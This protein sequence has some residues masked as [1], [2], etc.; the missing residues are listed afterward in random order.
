MFQNSSRREFI[1][2]MSAALASA[3]GLAAQSPSFFRFPYVQDVRRTRATI[4]WTTLAP[5]NGE[6]EYWDD[7]N[8]RLRA[9]ASMTAFLPAETGMPA[10]YYRFESVLPKLDPGTAYA[11]RVLMG[12]QPIPSPTLSFRTPGT[13]PFDF[14]VFGDSGTGSP[15]QKQIAN[16]LLNR[17][18]GFIVHTGDLVYPSGTFE[19]YESLYF[20]YYRDLMRDVPFFP[21]PGNHD[22]YETSCIPYR[23]IH[24]LPR[25]TVSTSDYG[26]YYSFDWGNAHFISLDSNDSLWEAVNG[27]GRMLQWLDNDLRTTTKF[28]RI[29]VLHHPAYSAG[30]HSEEPEAEMV[31]NYIAPILDKYSVP[32]VLNGHEHSYQRS[33]P[34]TG[35]RVAARG[36]GTL[37]I[38]TGG[39]GADLH[40]V[41]QAETVE[42]AESV[43]HFLTCN[44]SGTKLK[45]QAVRLDG[46]ELDSFTVTPKPIASENH[47]VNSASYTGQLAAGGLVSIFG[48]HLAPDDVTPL[49]FPL[50]KAA[51]GTAVLLGDRPLP[52]L[53]ASGTQINVQLPFDAVGSAD[54][55]VRTPNGSVTMPVTIHSSAPALFDG[56]VFHA[57]GTQVTADSPARVG[58]ELNVYLTGLGA[59]ASS[60]AVAGEAA[61]RIA[62]AAAVQVRWNTQ[63]VTPGFAGLLQGTAGVDVVTFR[64]PDNGHGRASLQIVADGAVS[65]VAVVP[66]V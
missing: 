43:H 33:A 19:R 57:N 12:G 22:Y 24:S 38:T 25:D 9:P 17:E 51:A 50:P 39:G 47:V 16:L 56:A 54:L 58:E 23:A 10:P 18:A 32:L 65:N 64:V 61:Q 11:Y 6:V 21:C 45:I 63:P 5:G 13:A 4:R 36:E 26:R 35:G 34:I 42:I 14:L 31:R 29:V 15:E 55:T 28:W 1:R 3:A 41:S 49:A 8:V 30:K 60:G 40:P 2:A 44:V 62:S 37:Y 46:S 53:M 59:P 27:S 48:Y 7:S 20:D 66:V 52:I